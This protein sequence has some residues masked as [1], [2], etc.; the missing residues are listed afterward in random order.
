MNPEEL[1]RQAEEAM[2]GP[3]PM[4]EAQINAILAA[5]TPYGSL[6]DLRAA[7]QHP[8]VSA[9]PTTAPPQQSAGKPHIGTALADLVTLMA[10]S[11]R[12]AD[13]L[14]GAV[15]VIPGALRG[16]SPAESFREGRSRARDRIAQAQERA[17][18]GGQAAAEVMAGL[19]PVTKGFQIFRGLF[20]VGG[21]TAPG[22]A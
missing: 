19:V 14:V 17:G 11:T 21:K 16:Q 22:D 12:G 10:N 2:S 20:N 15:N 7:V 8:F 5:E 13:E 3:D 6:A 9:S 1:L 18:P 4:T